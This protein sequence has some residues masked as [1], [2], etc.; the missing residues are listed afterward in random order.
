MSRPLR[1]I[2][3]TLSVA[4]AAALLAAC[5]GSPDPEAQAEHAATSGSSAGLPRGNVDAGQQASL[6][7][8]EATGQ[9][10][11]DCHGAAGNV[12]LDPTYP[13]IGG[14]FRDYLAHALQQYRD[15]TRDHALMS[16][17]AANLTDQQIADLAAYFA[18]QP[19]ELRD[20]RGAH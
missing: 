12:P 6:I 3:Q 7:K 15:G 13:K 10:C 4:L 16:Q 19:S 18:A 9:T 8:S 5:G 11:I 2:A 17:Q 20:L 1:L 14:Q